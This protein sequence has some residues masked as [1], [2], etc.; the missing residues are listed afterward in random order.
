MVEGLPDEKWQTSGQIIFEVPKKGHPGDKHVLIKV[1]FT[2]RM[3]SDVNH[4]LLER[5]RKLPRSEP[6]TRVVSP[7]M[8]P[9]SVKSTRRSRYSACSVSRQYNAQHKLV[10]ENHAP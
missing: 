1:S 8:S 5:R 10:N 2:R 4:R 7:C 6:A 3:H 9:R